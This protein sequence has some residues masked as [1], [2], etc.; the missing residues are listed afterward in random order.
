MSSDDG[1]VPNFRVKEVENMEKKEVGHK[2][3]WDEHELSESFQNAKISSSQA[4]EEMT[5]NG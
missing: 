4:M 3:S 5:K 2:N 1:D